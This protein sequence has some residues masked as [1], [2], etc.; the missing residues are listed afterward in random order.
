MNTGNYMCVHVGTYVGKY[1]VIAVYV[2][3]GLFLYI[4]DNVTLRS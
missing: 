1:I 2:A 4:Y 3:V